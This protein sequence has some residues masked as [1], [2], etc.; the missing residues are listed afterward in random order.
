MQIRNKFLRTAFCL[1]F[2]AH[3]S[4][5]TNTVPARLAI[6]AESPDAAP[7][8]DVLTA[9]F[10]KDDRV[11]LLE[12]AEIEKVIHEQQ[13][14]LNNADDLKLG[15]LLGAD[16][17]LFLSS[18]IT[19]ESLPMGVTKTNRFLDVRL[20]AV[21]PGVVLA[22]E[23]FSS[24]DQD[25]TSW[26]PQ[27]VDHL[28]PLVGKLNV[29]AGDAI[30]VSIV[31]FRSAISSADAPETERQLQTLAIQ[32]LSHEPK[33]FV[34]ERQRLQQLVDEKQLSADETAFWDGAWLLE[35]TID[36]NGFSKDLV[37]LSAQLVPAKGGAP[38]LIE[39]SGSRTNFPEVIDQLAGKIASSLKITSA[40]K[41]WNATDEAAHFFDEAQWAQRWGAL[42]ES[43]MAADTAW[44]LGKK[45]LDCALLRVRARIGQI[46]ILVGPGVRMSSNGRLVN[47][48]HINDPPDVRYCDLASQALECFAAFS[49]ISPDGEPKVLTRGPGWNDWHDS[50]WYQT[51]ID[52]VE[53]ASHVLA[54][55][56]YSPESQ[57]S[58]ADKLA[59]LRAE[60][61]AVAEFIAEA[62][63]VHDSY[64]TGNRPATYD[65]LEPTFRERSNIFS[66]MIN[67]GCYWQERPEDAIAL[68]RKLT[69][70]PVYCYIQSSLWQREN[71]RPRLVAWDDEGRQRIP[72]VWEDFIRELDGSTNLLQRLE[73]HVLQL[74]DI[75]DE[76]QRG[77]VYTNFLEEIISN[78][79]E[80]VANPVDILYQDWTGGIVLATP[81]DSS[82]NPGDYRRILEDMQWE[83]LTKTLRAAQ[84]STAFEQ[85]R[86]FLQDN[87]HASFDFNKFMR[88]FQDRSY[89]PAQA[90]VLLPLVIAYKSNLLAQAAATNGMQKYSLQSDASVVGSFLQQ[91]VEKA[92]H[93][94]PP[95]SW[96]PPPVRPEPLRAA[97][98]LKPEAQPQGTV[99]NI[100]SVDKFLEIPLDG[101][102]SNEITGLEC[103]AHQW[104]NG[105]LLVDFQVSVQIY[106]YDQNGNW[107]ST[108]G[109]NIP[110]IAVLDM[111][112][113]QWQVVPCP[114]V[115]VLV[116]NNFYHH[117]I[118][119]HGQIFNSDGNEVRKFDAS[120]NGW[121]DLDLPDVGN[122]ELFN[123][124]DHLY[125]ANYNIIVEILDDGST[126]I[127]ASNRRQPPVSVLDTANLGTPVLFSG[128]GGTLRAAL[129]DGIFSWDGTNWTEVCPAPSNHQPAI[130]TDEAA[131][132]LDDSWNTAGIWRLPFG[133]DQMEYSM[134]QSLGP[135]AV[136]GPA[137]KPKPKPHWNYSTDLPLT[138]LAVASHGTDLYLLVGRAR[139]EN[140]VDE[141]HHEIIGKKILP[142]DGYHAELFCY[143]SNYPEP[144]KIFL[145]FDATDMTVP[146]DDDLGRP[147]FSA[148]G[149]PASWLLACGDKLFIG[150]EFPN[151]ILASGAGGSYRSKAGVWV[152]SLEQIDGEVERQ[153]KLQLAQLAQASAAKESAAKTMLDVFDW[154]HDGVIDGGEKE[155]ALT[156]KDYIAWQLDQIDANQNGLLDAAELKFFD[157]NS[158]NILDRNERAGIE[159]TQRLLAERLVRKFDRDGNGLLDRM[160]FDKLVKASLNVDSRNRMGNPF[161]DENH[162]NFMD[163]EEVKDFI[164]AQTRRELP[165][166]WDPRHDFN[167]LV[168]NYWQNRGK[169]FAPT[170]HAPMPPP[171][172]QS[173]SPS[174]SNQ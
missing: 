67:W 103:I 41:E 147:N 74:A 120:T 148:P 79:A 13:L 157:A 90:Q 104:V 73:G 69:E 137:A 170:F 78:R 145:K 171:F 50:D 86:K 98:P 108:R 91:P 101:F 140:I 151:S 25:F 136:G 118:W 139:L 59:D 112:T 134:G 51:G 47:I 155:A 57:K 96:Q 97:V 127:L 158:N 66:T 93:P 27:Y 49:R 9:E 152:A 102:S 115:D 119:W 26:A 72:R 80:L 60:T 75:T 153:K 144:Q 8:V 166:S 22:A 105:K 52:T 5:Q 92:L 29:P 53:A 39:V 109:A 129:A 11:Q 111:A 165:D 46:P 48:V 12:R 35:G 17:V 167:S 169:P 62:P 132:F 142:Q 63:S 30:P 156:N 128:P 84:M 131:L 58:A 6:V 61:R 110:A 173:P 135:G 71:W 99:T 19:V 24:P 14:S 81:G 122:C 44:A 146:V 107:K 88:A 21:K 38:V 159:I 162:D 2:A 45:D 10:S 163:V 15:R 125:A 85:Q 65:E 83:Y 168:E 43:Q 172:M 4:A 143:S 114:E 106:D 133:A 121:R 54:E 76:K 126:R 164:E 161:P 77:A 100:I 33:F 20:L 160:E 1:M 18:S 154:N 149:S 23:R 3:I 68:Y 94:E 123:V 36:Q 174:P 55:F 28:S 64:Y 116:R 70:S 82:I 37:T 141:Q 40:V 113:E 31:N 130:Q 7:I 117:T 56:N 89:T 42:E 150:R 34:L 87:E 95:S 138:R 32:R 16:G 124:N